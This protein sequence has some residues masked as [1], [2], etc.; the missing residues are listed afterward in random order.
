M[1]SSR[2][3]RWSLGLGAT[4]LLSSCDLFLAGACDHEYRD[5]VLALA[6]R[7]GGPGT[8]SL[9]GFS[10]DG[11]AVSALDQLAVPPAFHVRVVDD[12]LICEV[13]CGFGVEEGRYTFTA[14]A[15]GFAPTPVDVEARYDDFDSGCPSSN[16][17]STQI[18][19]LLRPE[20]P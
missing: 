17:G 13:P 7:S 8:I 6:L 20:E 11:R 1:S 2:P 3:I 16:S 9:S 12:A 10:I 5:P 18:A 15:S 14:G 19:V 4:C